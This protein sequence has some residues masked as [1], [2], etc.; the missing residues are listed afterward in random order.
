[1]LEYELKL[2]NFSYPG[3]VVI[4]QSKSNSE[5]RFYI[6]PQNKFKQTEPIC[7]RCNRKAIDN[8]YYKNRTKLVNE[9]GLEI[10]YGQYECEC[11]NRWSVRCEEVDEFVARYKN[12]IKQLVFNLCGF[13][14]SLD[15]IS[16]TVLLTFS[17][18]I[19]KEWIRQLFLK[20]AS[21][22]RQLKVTKTSGIFHYDEQVVW[23]NGKK[24][25]RFVIKDAVLKNVILDKKFD[26]LEKET[27]KEAIRIALAHYNVSV[28]ITDMDL[29]Y[30]DILNELYPDSKHQ[31]CIFHLNKLILKEFID[32]L[33]KKIPLGQLY[34]MYSL[35]NLFFNHDKEINFLKKQLK[36]L[37][38]V[39]SKEYEKQ[40]INEFYKYRDSLKRNRRRKMGSKLKKRTKNQ[41]LKLL[42]KI[43]NEAFLY[44]KKLKKRIKLIR[45]NLD[46][47]AVFQDNPLVPP[48]NNNVEHYYSSTLQKTDKKRF[49]SD[50]W[51]NAKLEL[52][53]AR[54][55]GLRFG[56]VNFFEFLVL[57][58]KIFMLF[59]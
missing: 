12:I 49:R 52:F 4:Q 48:T 40:L 51:L 23:I 17:K 28:F 56:V 59:S 34:N 11:G 26:N 22:I 57:C 3:T 54:E 20:A 46:K 15:K 47:F 16:E 18:N 5:S 19:S 50:S 8:G 41:T 33:G 43:E 24:F 14:L 27:V 21:N 36:K 45:K 39:E 7:T 38:K 9:L 42:S 25:F 44:P 58:G 10:K 30:P 32:S 31:L 37:S 1:M 35:F 53:K 6:T 13:G 55:N 29:K 2:N